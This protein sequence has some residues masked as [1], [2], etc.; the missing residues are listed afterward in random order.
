[1]SM[2]DYNR[3]LLSIIP[4]RW[5]SHYFHLSVVVL[6][7]WP[8]NQCFSMDRFSSPIRRFVSFYPIKYSLAWTTV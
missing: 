1:M 7:L 8:L 4:G 5:V 3:C 2:S 6:V